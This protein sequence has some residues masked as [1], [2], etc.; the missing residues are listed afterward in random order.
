MRSKKKKNHTGGVVI[1][2]ND[3]P[4]RRCVYAVCTY[5]I[6]RAYNIAGTQYSSRPF[7]N[8]RYLRVV[9]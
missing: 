1:R 9:V 3:Y 7:Q 6:R 8:H 2:I 5:N 4:R